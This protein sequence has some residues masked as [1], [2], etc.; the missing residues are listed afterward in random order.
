MCLRA[1][2][3]VIWRV[4]LQ[5]LIDFI[6]VKRLILILKLI[7]LLRALLIALLIAFLIALLR[8]F[9]R[10]LLKALCNDRPPP[11]HYEIPAEKQAEDCVRPTPV[12]QSRWPVGRIFNSSQEI[13]VIENHGTLFPRLW[14]EE[15]RRRLQTR[16]RP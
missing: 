6:G 4:V 15:Q 11:Y 13:L 7:A 12:G 16:T 1:H 5:L 10:A 8:A 9:L 14:G 2:L 3:Y